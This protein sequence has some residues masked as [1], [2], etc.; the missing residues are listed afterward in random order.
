MLFGVV[1]LLLGML[2]TPVWAMTATLTAPANGARYAAPAAITLSAGMVVDSGFSPSYVD[3]YDGDTLLGRATSP[4]SLTVTGLQAKAY[5]FRA[6]ATAHSATGGPRQANTQTIDVTVGASAGT[7]AALPGILD[8]ILSDADGSGSTPVPPVPPVSLDD[9]AGMLPTG[10]AAGSLPGTFEVAASGAATYTIPLGLPSGSG[11]MQP[12]LGLAYS[13]QGGYSPLGMGWSLTGLSAVSRCPKSR[14]IDGEKG[15]VGHDANDRFCLD[16][17]RLIAVSGSYGANGTEYRTQL[18]SFSKIVSYGTLG[19]G[20][21][22]FRVWT[23]SGLIVDYGVTADSRLLANAAGKTE[24]VSWSQ[25]SIA[26]V[27]GNTISFVYRNSLAAG[28]QVP[29]EIRYVTNAG[30]GLTTPAT[31]VRFE[32]VNRA[33]PASATSR[34][35][36]SPAPCC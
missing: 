10:A 36:N 14:F 20:P 18:E 22:Y 7:L 11:G 9:P 2:A 16:G 1:M 27:R 29:E 19:S 28:E 32:Y 35:A 8:L 24:A 6:A 31:V 5:R 12:T 34:A 4:F 21:Q 17:Q 30:A 26:D 15:S 3:F 33:D 23:K 13:S 25:S